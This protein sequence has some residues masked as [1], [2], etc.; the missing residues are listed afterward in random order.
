MKSHVRRRCRRCCCF[1]FHH[2]AAHDYGHCLFVRWRK[3]RKKKRMNKRVF[4]G[5]KCTIVCTILSRDQQN[6]IEICVCL[7]AHFIIFFS[8]YCILCCR[9]WVCTHLH[10]MWVKTST[11]FKHLLFYTFN[12]SIA[13]FLLLSLYSH[14]ESVVL[15]FY[16]WFCSFHFPIL[17]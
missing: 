17:I 5:N 13:L 11:S 10:E 2:N 14:Y 16:I 1:H 4:F 6:V 3:Q 8:T 15:K 12:P 9:K 7:C